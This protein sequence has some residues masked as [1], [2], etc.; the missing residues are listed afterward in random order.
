MS[1]DSLQSPVR[2][3]D[4][5][6][7]LFRIVIMLVII[8]HHYVVNS[9]LSD[10][11]FAN[12]SVGP[13]NVFLALLGCG[14]KTG[15]NCFVL[16][17]GYYLCR[18]HFRPG[19]FLRLFGEMEFYTIIIYFIFAATGYE[20]LSLGT[21]LY[22]IS[23]FQDVTTSFTYCFLLFYL[24]T[25]FLSKM[26]AALNQREHL[27]LTALCLFIYTFLPSLNIGIAVSFNYFTWFIVLALVGSYLERYPR[28]W[29]SRTALWGALSLASLALSF[30][31][32]LWMMVRS[33]AMGNGTYSYSYVYY[34]VIDSNKILALVTAVCL[35][36]F[37]KNI[38]LPYSRIINTIA[39][40]VFGVLLIHANSDAMRHWLWQDF[41]H[42][43]SLYESRW[44]PLHAA[45]SILGVF[46]V[47]VVID[48]IR[49]RL[50]ER[51][52]E[53]I[54]IRIRDKLQ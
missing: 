47:C 51:P 8:A 24:A 29:F 30:G 52:A 27:G 3:R 19:K 39:S 22:Y 26:I 33:V 32:V 43:P 6:L 41:L 14:G 12:P 50:I 48:Q 40:S 44:L 16:I 37:F 28:P 45:L 2:K 4:S 20:K 13:Y 17:T 10:L 15:I 36:M 21:L 46:A 9:G 49:I 35:F 5:N 25:P 54:C 42:C 1:E 34:Y 18:S 31:S 53:K 38:R 11:I 23:P 7:E